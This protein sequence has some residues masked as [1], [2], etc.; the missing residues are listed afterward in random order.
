M[1]KYY[2]VLCDEFGTYR[3]FFS[4]EKAREAKTKL[5]LEDCAVYQLELNKIYYDINAIH[6]GYREKVSE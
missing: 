6:Y 2:Y 4:E 3:I 1:K 5:K